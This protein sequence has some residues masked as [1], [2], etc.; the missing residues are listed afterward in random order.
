MLLDR[1]R[2]H[3][4]KIQQTHKSISEEVQQQHDE[5]EESEMMPM[6]MSMPPI[7]KYEGI[8]E[9]KPTPMVLFPKDY[10]I[11]SPTYYPTV[12]SSYPTYSPT[13]ADY[14][15][16]INNRWDQKQ[17]LRSE[18]NVLTTT[19]EDAS[20]SSVDAVVVAI[21]IMLGVALVGPALYELSKHGT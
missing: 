18:A 16:G 17:V 8:N 7:L 13:A 1:H 12:E 19:A 2:C 6:I 10:L 14:S 11:H 15:S 21:C 9:N 3:H 5:M 4:R 20:G